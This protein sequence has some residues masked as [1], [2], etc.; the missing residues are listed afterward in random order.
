M[1]GIAEPG[2]VTL[3]QRAGAVE[4]RSADGHEDMHERCRRHGDGLAG[5]ETAALQHGVALMDADCAS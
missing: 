1:A 4:L 5:G 2:R 3:V